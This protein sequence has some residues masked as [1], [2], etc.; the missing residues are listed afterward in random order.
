MKQFYILII[1]SLLNLNYLSAQITFEWLTATDNGSTITETIDGITVTFHGANDETSDVIINT[2]SGYCNSSNNVS[3][4]ITDTMLVSFSFSEPVDIASIIAFNGRGQSNTYTFTA[5]GGENSPVIASIV[6]GCAPAVS[7]NWI[8]VTSFTVSTPTENQFGFDNLVL[9]SSST[10]SIFDISLKETVNVF[11]NPTSDFIQISGLIEDEKY[12]IYSVLGE[13]LK[14]GV[15][16]S[17]EKIGI[18]HLNKGMYFLKLE[19]GNTLKFI[20]E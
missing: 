16:S 9:K 11:P 3:W 6:D 13:E 5:I 4:E 12:I 20:K 2:P 15:I 17:K 8:N 10:L 1:I 19:N 18:Q 14:N 7:L